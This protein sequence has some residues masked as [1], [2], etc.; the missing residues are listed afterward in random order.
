MIYPK[1]SRIRQYFNLMSSMRPEIREKQTHIYDL[2]LWWFMDVQSP[3]YAKRKTWFTWV[4]LSPTASKR[5]RHSWAVLR[6]TLEIHWCRRI[7]MLCFQG[8]TMT[9]GG[10]GDG[11]PHFWIYRLLSE[12]PAALENAMTLCV[13]MLQERVPRVPLGGFRNNRTI[14]K[15]ATSCH[16][17][18]Q[19]HI[20]PW[21]HDDRVF[22]PMKD[23]HWYVLSKLFW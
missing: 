12:L 8:W 22:R 2:D 21:E 20:K 18:H 7:V 9:T 14:R 11:M 16:Q 10:I 1:K 13:S 17:Q 4:H 6:G 3:Q 23:M 15:V 19:S 5:C